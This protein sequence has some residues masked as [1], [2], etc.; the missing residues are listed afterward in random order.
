MPTDDSNQ[1]SSDQPMP[2]DVVQ[3]FFDLQKRELDVRTQE[4]QLNAQQE[5]NQ[6][7]IAEISIST[8][9]TD[10]DNHRDH[11]E[12]KTKIMLF[13]AAGIMAIIL[14]FLGSALYMG[15]EAVVMKAT[16][17]AIIFVAGFAGG[18]GTKASRDKKNS[19][20]KS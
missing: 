19:D 1:P 4:L 13:G 15:K 5:Q 18:Y 14:I 20:E 12:R 17:L 10:R 3:N 2:P 6:K 9:L 7:E 16:E 8:N 11:I